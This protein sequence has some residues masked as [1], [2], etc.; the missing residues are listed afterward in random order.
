MAKEIMV[1]ARSKAKGL[2]SLSEGSLL[3]AITDRL[4][5]P[6]HRTPLD[7]LGCPGDW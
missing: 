3:V 5:G 7:G 1:V 2:M 4:K 6:L